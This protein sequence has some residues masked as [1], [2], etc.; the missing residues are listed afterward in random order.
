MGKVLIRTCTRH[1]CRSVQ[2]LSSTNQNKFTPSMNPTINLCTGTHLNPLKLVGILLASLY[3]CWYNRKT[4]YNCS[5]QQKI[6][7]AQFSYF[8]TAESKHFQCKHICNLVVVVELYNIC[9]VHYHSWFGSTY[10]FLTLLKN[11]VL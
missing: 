6:N 2:V 5:I 4:V 9:E 8:I 1:K 3:P 11:I 10:V 7:N